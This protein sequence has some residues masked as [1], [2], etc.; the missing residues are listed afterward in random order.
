MPLLAIPLGLLIGLVLPPSSA[1]KTYSS[2]SL[3]R[4]W[5]IRSRLAR[6]PDTEAQQAGG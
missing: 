5:A 4:S 6:P 2:S 1:A 3:C